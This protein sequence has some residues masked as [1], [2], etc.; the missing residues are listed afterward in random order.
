MQGQM[1]QAQTGYTPTIS[2]EA[3]FTGE[4]TGSF[5]E[6]MKTSVLALI[7][8]Y[9]VVET[10]EM[11]D[12]PKYTSTKKNILLMAKAFRRL[13]LITEEQANC[14]EELST[15]ISDWFSSKIPDSDI[16]TITAHGKIG[17]ELIRRYLKRLSETG[18]IGLTGYNL[19]NTYPF[20]EILL[21][22]VG[23]INRN[24]LSKFDKELIDFVLSRIN[25]D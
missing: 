5:M 8:I 24:N 15:D 9:G 25:T 6:P 13:L 1:M 11:D 23:R 21:S 10:D 20:A 19:E 14:G 2:N 22:N 3:E 18:L 12:D 16:K 4:E 17:R 7:D